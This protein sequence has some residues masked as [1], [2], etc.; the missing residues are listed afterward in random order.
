MVVKRNFV[1]PLCAVRKLNI[2]L[3]K[4]CVYYAVY[5]FVPIPNNIS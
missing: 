3:L 2:G 5:I 4:T 1:R